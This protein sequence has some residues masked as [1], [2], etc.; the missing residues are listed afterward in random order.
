M[1]IEL[2]QGDP[3]ANVSASWQGKICETGTKRMSHRH[4]A[5]PHKGKTMDVKEAVK[6]AKTYV[7]DLMSDEGIENLGLEEVEFDD[8]AQQWRVTVGF[9]RPWDR[10]N[11]L[12]VALTEYGR[13]DRSYKVLS[14]NDSDGRIESLT[15]RILET[16]RAV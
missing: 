3:N 4:V 13:S 1:L 9:S 8:M 16:P 15:D 12:A 14:I 2:P 7:A 5:K 6:T 10:K 11:A